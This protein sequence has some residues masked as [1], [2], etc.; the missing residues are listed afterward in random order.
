[1]TLLH[2]VCIATGFYI[3]LGLIFP[4]LE[5]DTF[6]V[7]ALLT[8]LGYSINDTIVV[9]DR[10]RSGLRKSRKSD[11][12]RRHVFQDAIQ[13]SVRRSIFTSLT[14]LIVLIVLLLIGPTQL[15]GFVVLLILG[16][17]VGTY[18][19]L[20]IAAPLVYDIERKFQDAKKSH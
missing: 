16:T 12:S 5:L 17:I 6:F 1:V 15:L 13:S 19:S 2:D 14:L 18:S 7:T 4:F 10:I 9:L 3:F 8:I 11:K 20:F